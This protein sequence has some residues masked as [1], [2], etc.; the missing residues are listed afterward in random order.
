MIRELVDKIGKDIIETGY[1]DGNDIKNAFAI[2]VDKKGNINYLVFGEIDDNY[3]NLEEKDFY[4]QR[5]KYSMNLG[6]KNKEVVTTGLG[7]RAIISCHQYGVI[8]NY[9]TLVAKLDKLRN[10][11]EK[12]KIKYKKL[13][14]YKENIT[15]DELLE[16]SFEDYFIKLN[17]LEC[18]LNKY[19]K[20]ICEYIVQNEDLAKDKKIVILEDRPIKDYKEMYEEYLSVGIMNKGGGIEK[21]KEYN[22]FNTLNSSKPLLSSVGTLNNYTTLDKEKDII[23]FYKLYKYMVSHKT[24]I[25]NLGLGIELE[26]DKNNIYIV[27]Y[28]QEIYW[29]Y[30]D[31]LQKEILLNYIKE[32]KLDEVVL[33]TKSSII[34]ELNKYIDFS[35]TKGSKVKSKS[36]LNHRYK[37]I[38]ISTFF[39][40]KEVFHKVDMKK[41][42]AKISRLCDDI[43]EFN[44][45]DKDNKSSIT[46]L[47]NIL[48]LKFKLEECFKVNKGEVDKLR[49]IKEDFKNKIINIKNGFSIDSDSELMFAAGQI[50]YYIAS[51]SKSKTTRERMVSKYHK[52]R[53]FDRLKHA[54]DIDKGRYNFLNSNRENIIFCEIMMKIGSGEMTS[55]QRKWYF[56]GLYSDNLLF[57]KNPENIVIN[58]DSNNINVKEGN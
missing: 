36:I 50:A 31:Q 44:R 52:I 51:K 26:I 13:R 15:M 2:R 7:A 18:I 27:N 38:V 16:F 6:L 20:E 14:G 10:P 4:N 43:I 17:S 39:K 40:E 11:S 37:D 56:V 24:D 32:G 33:R 30:K 47:R 12:D 23:E 55:D 35:M 25:R 3:E 54:L 9:N 19:K 28:N 45:L 41:L 58:P 34:N 1:L 46:R 21:Y 5:H 42:K 29:D 49:E 53:V 8:F 57:T 22:L 48:E